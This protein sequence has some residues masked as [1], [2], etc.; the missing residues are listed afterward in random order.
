MQ[1]LQKVHIDPNNEWAFTMFSE[2]LGKVLK[3]ITRTFSYILLKNML[4]V[5]HKGQ[6]T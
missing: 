3:N 4:T 2:A 5:I 1:C 6:D